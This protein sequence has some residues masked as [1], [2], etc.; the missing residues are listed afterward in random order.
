MT[1][2]L[3]NSSSKVKIRDNLLIALYYVSGYLRS[4]K[5][6]NLA[7]G[8]D[9]VEWGRITHIYIYTHKERG[10]NGPG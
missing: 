7:R 8:E 5:C 3:A 4:L 10:H 9:Q 2:P 1:T 6:A